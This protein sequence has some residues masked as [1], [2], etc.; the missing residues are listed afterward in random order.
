MSA[1]DAKRRAAEASLAL[2]TP[3]M[4]LGLGT[5]STAEHLVR[6][7]GERAR[8]GLTL[9]AVVP[10]S[11]ATRRLAE[12]EGLPVSS[13]ER[14]PRLD[15]TIDGAD[16][17]AP[18]LS[19]I[20]GGGGA[21]LHEKIVASASDRLA[22]IADASKRVPALGAFP[23]EVIPGAAPV[24]AP[25][26]EGLGAQVTLRERGGAPFRTDEGN[27]VLDCAF[28]TI[29]DPR[30]LA[31]TLDGIPGLVE[32]GLFVDLADIAFVATADAVEVLRR[33][34]GPGR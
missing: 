16:E 27:L 25:A 34:D 12:A 7:L 6:L 11:A 4:R 23:L 15:L 20:K 32:H 9:A 14:T 1:T 13:L 26:L 33:A 31:R 18:D 3:G 10:T 21:H 2:V 17:I 19:L 22:V 29:A 8:A 30:A 24:V 5:G 28:G